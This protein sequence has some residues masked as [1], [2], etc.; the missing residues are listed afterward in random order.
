MS[1][2]CSICGEETKRDYRAKYCLS[3][4]DKKKKDGSG[5]KYEGRKL[6]EK[7]EKKDP[8]YEEARNSGYF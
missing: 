5:Y 6:V 2:E 4:A 8:L 1:K 7:I 3:C